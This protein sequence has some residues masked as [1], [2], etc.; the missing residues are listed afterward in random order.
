MTTAPR[1]PRA[2][3]YA[4]PLTPTEP[5]DGP[6]FICPGCGTKY[7]TPDA[8]ARCYGSEPLCPACG[9]SLER[10]QAADG[11]TIAVCEHCRIAIREPGR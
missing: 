6:Q 7:A 10:H 8:A 3:E 4:N 9:D 11:T 1:G 5:A 2:D